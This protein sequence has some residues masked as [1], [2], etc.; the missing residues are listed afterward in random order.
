MKSAYE[1][2]ALLLTTYFPMTIGDKNKPFTE[3][4]FKV[5]P[6]CLLVTDLLI[7]Q[8]ADL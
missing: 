2:M 8:H 4:E 6:Q 5:D 7:Y 3:V 1:I